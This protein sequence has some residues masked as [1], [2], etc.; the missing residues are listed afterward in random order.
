MSGLFWLDA[1]ALA[2]SLNNMILLTWLGLTILLNAERRTRGIWFIGGSLLLASLF[3]AGHSVILY[4]GLDAL[5]AGL[6]FWWHLIWVPVILLPFSWYLVTLWYAGF[7]E[8]AKSGRS[9]PGP[10]FLLAT[11]ATVGIAVY[12][13][14]ANPLP[15][16]AKSGSL[17]LNTPQIN[18]IPNLLIVYSADMLLCLVLALDALRRPGP[19]VRVMG[20]LARRRA[21][22]WLIATSLVL[23]AVGCLAILAMFWLLLT[24][25]RGLPPDR[26]TLVTLTWF[27]IVVAALSALATICVG[28]AVARYEVFTGKALPR[29]GF[30]RQWRNAVILA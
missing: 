11:L 29:R 16:L 4:L 21:R 12:L 30:I 6:D 25:P 26:T 3:F 28:Q 2:V 15:S 27:D 18:G 9:R 10:W 22:P 13:A 17:D 20:D 14:L 5:D 24:A 19:T 8:N 1:T 23:F 7:W